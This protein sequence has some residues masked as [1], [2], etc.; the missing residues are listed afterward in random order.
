MFDWVI[1]IAVIVQGFS[2]VGLVC[3]TAW[4]AHSVRRQ[5]DQDR[6]FFDRNGAQAAALVERQAKEHQQREE[7]RMGHAIRTILAELEIDSQEG[8]WKYQESPPLLDSAYAANL[9]AV[10]LIGM[11]P[12][13]FR[14]LGN[15]YLNIKKYDLLYDALTE[16][17]RHEAWRRNA[18]R[19]A[20]QEAQTA[21][22]AALAALKE[23]SATMRLFATSERED[24]RPGRDGQRR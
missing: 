19:K 5:I 12:A 14:A 8:A 3:L 2:T 6:E 10:H 18:S 20:W 22:Q 16:A 23:D 24:R 7:E 21:I 4:Y 1:A 15:A 9:W 17:G 13:T 11:A